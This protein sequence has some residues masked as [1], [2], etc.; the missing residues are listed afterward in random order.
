L[1]VVA[2]LGGQLHYEYLMW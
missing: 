2:C 1:I